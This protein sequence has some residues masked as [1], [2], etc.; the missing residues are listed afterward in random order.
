LEPI[1][2]KSFDRPLRKAFG[3][4][5]V[6]NSLM[7]LSGA[8]GNALGL[9]AFSYVSGAI[10]APTAFLIGR[11]VKPSGQSIVEVATAGVKALAFSIVFYTVVVWILLRLWPALRSARSKSSK[12]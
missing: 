11:M 2:P 9:S 6:I 1:S 5:I 12:P 10:A 7:G 4:S 8:L 3:I